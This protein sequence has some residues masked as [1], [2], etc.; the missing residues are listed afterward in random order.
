M[1]S[2]RF[3]AAVLLNPKRAYR[4]AQEA[5]LHPS[6]LSKL[7]NGIERVK[8]GDVRVI[9]VGEILGFKPEECFDPPEGVSE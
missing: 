2:E 7:L 5:G 3:R 6:T 8:P 1:V 4:I 9:K